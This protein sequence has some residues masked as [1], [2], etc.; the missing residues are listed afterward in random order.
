M[1]INPLLIE[2]GKAIIEGVAR[3]K[4]AFQ[5]IIDKLEECFGPLGYSANVVTEKKEFINKEAL[6]AIAKSNV[7]DGA[8]GICVLLKKGET[9]YTLWLANIK[10]NDFIPVEQNKFVKIE[11]EAL[12]RDI[13]S[14]FEKSEIIILK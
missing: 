10:D 1:V 2:K 7:V 3:F 8:N 14:L 9:N 4:V 11:A 12:S 5:P 6:I 13:E